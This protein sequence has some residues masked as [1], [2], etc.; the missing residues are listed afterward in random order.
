[1][2]WNRRV[3]CPEYAASSRVFLLAIGEIA[4]DTFLPT[5]AYSISA[6]KAFL[7]HSKSFHTPLLISRLDSLRPDNRREPC[8]RRAT[9]MRHYL[10]LFCHG[11]KNRKHTWST[12]QD[13]LN[14]SPA[15]VTRNPLFC[16]RTA[17]EAIPPDVTC[18]LFPHVTVSFVV[19]P[20]G[21]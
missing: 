12:R 2:I 13:G 14:P 9:C 7:S 3:S 18:I 11:Y 19:L 5:G 8:S 6:D 15:E 4:L 17:F 10:P 1:M 16:F 21:V 20:L